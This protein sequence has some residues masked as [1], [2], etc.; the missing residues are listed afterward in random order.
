MNE[1]YKPLSYWIRKGGVYAYQAGE[2]E[3]VSADDI[4]HLYR[5]EFP[6]QVRGIPPFNGV[7]LDLKQLDDYRTSELLAA[8]AGA[9][10]SVFYE[11]NTMTNSGD[12]LDRSVGTDEEDPGV[13]VQTLEPGVASVAPEGYNV[14]TLA[15]NH[16]QSGFE[17]FN[18]AVLKQI[19]SSLG[20]SYNKMIKDYES[21]SYSALKEASLDESGFYQEFQQFMI[22]GWKEREYQEFLK[23]ELKNNEELINQCMRMHTWI[24]QRRPY[25]DRAKEI[26]GEKYSLEM[27]VKNPIELIESEGKDVDE[28]LK[29]WQLW[30]NLCKDYDVSFG[31]NESGN[32]E[33]KSVNEVHLSPIEDESEEEL[34][35]KQR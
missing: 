25:V 13:F 7:L 18:K 23:F 16:P 28:V 24:C 8:K 27:G 2:I 30:K 12:F 32:R 21:A 22:E 9:C 17:Q 11:R 31:A 35:D 20:C 10:L 5:R 14:K 6:N 3:K 33:V 19:A 15:P 26:V 34:L 4:I 29:G 1:Y